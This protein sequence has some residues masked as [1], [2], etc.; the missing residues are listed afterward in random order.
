MKRNVGLLTLLLLVTV[1]LVPAAFAE[2]FGVEKTMQRPADYGN[3]ILNNFSG[4]SGIAPVVFKHWL[5][6]DKFTCRLCHVDLGFAMKVGATRIKE[7]DIRSGLY[8]GA[9]HNG[10]IAFSGTKDIHGKAQDNCDRCHSYGKHVKFDKTFAQVTK[11]FPRA[12]FGNKVDWL[13]AEDLGLI[14]L[15]DQIPGLTIKRK[16]L[17]SPKNMVL[18][19]KVKSM[20]S[21]IFSHKKHAVWNGCAMCHPYLFG[22]K[23]GASTYSMQDIFNGKY[24]GACHGKVSFPLLDCRLCH[25]K[26]MY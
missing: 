24:C 18:H 11:G 6:R 5:H 20:P 14:H 21:I 4:R 15:Q 26:D 10:K 23:K 16:P 13:K 22:I 7:E 19:A 1:V 17:K 8:C 3:V 9:C 25:T 2:T 12:R